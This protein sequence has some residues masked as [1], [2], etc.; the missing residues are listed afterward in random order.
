[1]TGFVIG[2][3]VL[4]LLASACVAVP[5]LARRAAQPRAALAAAGAILLLLAGAAGV[6]LARSNWSWKEQ[7]AAPASTVAELMQRVS[8]DPG[9]RAGWLALGESYAQI[10]QFPLALR[11]YEQAN[12]LGGGN[13]AAALAGMGEAMLLT[14]DAAPTAAAS[15]LLERALKA[16]PQSPKALF[17]TALLAMKG[18]RLELARSRFS[19]MLELNPPENV[20]TVLTGEIA[21]IDRMLHPPVDRA[22]LIDLQIDVAP[23]LRARVPAEGSL[24]VFVRN[25]AGGPPLAVK[26]LPTALPVHVQLSAVDSMLGPGA[27]SGGQQVQVV[28]RLSAAGRPVASS[29]DLFGQLEYRAGK[30]GARRLSI[31]QISP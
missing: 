2:A 1:M 29:G 18:G 12:A 19:A 9:D 14:G 25:P 13:D 26:R 16:D 21:T 8:R 28:A 22:T 4:A 5:L 3:A 24:F 23:A 15:D 31:D 10:G 7:P 30:D 27:I 6:Y 11:A 17:Y 20:R